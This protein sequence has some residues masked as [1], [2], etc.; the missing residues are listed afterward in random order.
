MVKM[1]V[2]TYVKNNY[3]YGKSPVISVQKI[4]ED[5]YLFG[6]MKGKHFQT[7]F[8]HTKKFSVSQ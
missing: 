8:Q 4:G 2:R 6:S 7:L 3:N 1:N 5:L